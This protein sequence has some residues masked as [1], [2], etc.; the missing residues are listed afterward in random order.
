MAN[1]QGWRKRH[2]IQIV[3]QLPENTADALAVLDHARDLVERFL[4]E[5]DGIAADSSASI[6]VLPTA[7]NSR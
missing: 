4:A 6:T 5:G 3:A 2:A 7:V 1:K